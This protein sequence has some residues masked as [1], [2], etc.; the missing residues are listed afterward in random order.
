[1]P[2]YA[3]YHMV[4]EV[5]LLLP[6]RCPALA[7][8]VGERFGRDLN[9]WFD[10]VEA[11]G[12]DFFQRAPAYDPQRDFHYVEIRLSANGTVREGSVG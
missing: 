3:R 9:K 5:Q 2:S 6:Q 12:I 4:H 11:A 10:D 8:K 7:R 1:M